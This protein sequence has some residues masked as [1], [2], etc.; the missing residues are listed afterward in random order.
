VAFSGAPKTQA[1]GILGIGPGEAAA[2]LQRQAEKYAQP[3]RPVLPAMELLVDVATGDPGPQGDYRNRVDP[4]VIDQYLA[5]ARADKMLMLL[6]LQPGRSGWMGEIRHL[7]RYLLQPDVGL[8]LEPEWSVGPGQVPGKVLGSIDAETVDQ[9]EAYLAGL[10]A[11]HGLP[12]KLLVVHQFTD[13]MVKDG[14]RIVPVPSVATVI[15]IDGYGQSSSKVSKY[16]L[17]EGDYRKGVGRGLKLYYTHDPDLLQPKEV[18][19]IV[20]SPDFVVYQ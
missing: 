1:L 16:Q 11:A 17:F 10:A 19:G 4:S 2:R 13:A 3:G 6:D 8:A 14:H 9:I 5:A 15:C 20:P 18:T 12:Q 7:Q